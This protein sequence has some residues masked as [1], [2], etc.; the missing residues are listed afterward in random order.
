MQSFMLA[1]AVGFLFTAI[2][3]RTASAPPSPAEIGAVMMLLVVTTTAAVFE[4]ELPAQIAYACVFAL[5]LRFAVRRFRASAGSRRPPAGFVLVPIAVAS[6]LVGAV[7]LGVS[8][9]APVPPWLERFGRL[10]VQQGVFLCLAAG[11]GSLVLPLMSGAAPPADLGSSTRETWKAIGYAA[12]GVVILASLAMEARGSVRAAPLLRAVA[13]T[14]GLCVAGGA[15]RRPGKP[16]L[17]RRFVWLS[18]WLIPLGLCLAGLWPEYRVPA[19]HVLFIGG[20]ALMAF[21]VATHVTLSHLGLETLREGRPPAVAFLGIAMLVAMLARVTADW[22]DSYFA[23][24]GWAAGTWLAGT[25][26]WLVFVATKL[27]GRQLSTHEP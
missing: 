27:R 10:L 3:R 7:L 26:V 18:V 14:L 4:Q 25:A 15:W 8:M 20:F 19:L 24:L 9:Q 13:V 22:T 6:G 23:H 11:V 17:H 16:G 5:V 2:P 1:F 21:G 12:I